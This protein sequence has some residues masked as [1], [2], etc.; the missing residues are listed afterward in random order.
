MSIIFELEAVCLGAIVSS[1]VW[2]VALA[3]ANMSAAGGLLSLDFSFFFG[4][5]RFLAYLF[6][7]LAL[8][9]LPELPKSRFLAFKLLSS[10]VTK[11]ILSREGA[12]LNLQRVT[13]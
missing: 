13:I 1:E 11:F 7:V 4:Y 6:F 12:R 5:F 10:I 3:A 9:H 8:E 2:F